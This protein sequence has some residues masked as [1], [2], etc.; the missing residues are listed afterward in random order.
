MQFIEYNK[1]NHP[2]LNQIYDILAEHQAQDKK[3]T[4][5]KVP[6]HMGIK[7]NEETDKAAKEVI[8]V[9]GVSKTRLPNTDYYLTIRRAR[10]SE[11]QRE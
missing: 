5:C 4:M 7:G 10:N 11:L 9:P 3:I 8:D 1:E 2:I 6:A